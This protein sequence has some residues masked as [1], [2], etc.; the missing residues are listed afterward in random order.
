MCA[1]G[2]RRIGRHP[3]VL[4]HTTVDTIHPPEAPGAFRH[5]LDRDM[6]EGMVVPNFRGVVLTA[7]VVMELD[8]ASDRSEN[9]LIT[10]FAP[11]LETVVCIFKCNFNRD[12]QTL[13]RPTYTL[14][15]ATSPAAPLSPAQTNVDI[16]A[17]VS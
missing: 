6:L 5:F 15:A 7:G 14:H 13:C 2:L 12:K 3:V 9:P 16:Q 8:L 11:N 17:Q 4:H 1:H 10:I